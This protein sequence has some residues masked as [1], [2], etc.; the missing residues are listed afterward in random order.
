MRNM[1]V[2]KLIS[3]ANLY[4]SSDNHITQFIHLQYGIETG[5]AIKTDGSMVNIVNIHT[6]THLST[7][8]KIHEYITFV[9]ESF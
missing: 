3:N 6:R 1:K 7:K 2:Q 4:F 9:R 8:S 5:H